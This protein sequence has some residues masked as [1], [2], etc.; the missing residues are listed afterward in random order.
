MSRAFL[1]LQWVRDLPHLPSFR[2]INSDPPV[3]RLSGTLQFSE[4]PLQRRRPKIRLILKRGMRRELVLQSLS[5]QVL[6]G[7]L[8]IRAHRRLKI[9]RRIERLEMLRDTQLVS[10]VE[11]ALDRI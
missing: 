11:R 4:Y 7:L 6:E 10:R 1:Q 9:E 5:Q 8:K 2:L 3:R